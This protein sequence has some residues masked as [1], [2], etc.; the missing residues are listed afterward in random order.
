[1]KIMDHHQLFEPSFKI[2][3][4]G[5][6]KKQIRGK[7][8]KALSDS[9]DNIEKKA[10]ENSQHIV[11]RALLPQEYRRMEDGTDLAD[12]D[13]TRI[14]RFFTYYIALNKNESDAE[15]RYYAVKNNIIRIAKKVGFRFDDF[16]LLSTIRQQLLI[17]FSQ[18][19]QQELCDYRDDV[20]E[21]ITQFDQHPVL[22]HYKDA[23][24]KID[25][26]DQLSCLVV[27]ASTWACWDKQN[28]S[29]CNALANVLLP[30]G[31]SA[32]KSAVSENE[33]KESYITQER[34]KAK[35][36]LKKCKLAFEQNR[37]SDCGDLAMQ[38]I[39]FN[40]ADDSVL[41][42]A[43]F[44]LYIC[45]TRHDYYA[46]LDPKALLDQS[47]KLGCSDAFH[48][49][50]LQDIKADPDST[51]LLRPVSETSGLARIVT[52]T[53]N[54]Y[55]E[56]FLL[57]IPAEMQKED[58][59]KKMILSATHKKQLLASVDA[60]KDTRYLLFDE[61]QEKNFQDL[62]YLLEKIASE[63]RK[64]EDS[65][66]ISSLRWSKTT[67]Y[68]RVSED[69]YSSLIDTALK[70]LGNFTVRVFVLDDAKRAAQNLLSDYPLYESIKGL[71]N[72]TLT[73]GPVC[74]NFTIICNG[75]TALTSWLIREA[76]WTSCFSYPGLTV[77][78]HLISPFAKEIKDELRFHFP[79]MFSD[80][81][82]SDHVSSVTVLEDSFPV[83]SL[84]DHRI[85]QNFDG[86]ENRKNAFNYYVVNVG[87][88]IE[89]LNYGIKLREWSIRNRVD[90]GKSLQSRNLPVIAFYCQNS[91]VAYLS[92]NMV[93]QTIDHG[94]RWYNNY[95]LKPF[96]MLRDSYSW[97]S[98]DGVY[99]EMASQ[100]MHLQYCGISPDDL[101][102]EKA[103]SLKDYFSRSYNRDSSMSAAR[104]L[105]YRLFQVRHAAGDHI[106][107]YSS[108]DNTNAGGENKEIIDSM[109][110]QF[111]SAITN[112]SLKDEL[113]HS[114]LYY[115]HSRWIRWAY[116]RGWKKASP[117]QVI[118]YMDAGNPKQQLFIARLHGC[119]CSIDELKILSET[120]LNELVPDENGEISHKKDWNR[121]ASG[122]KAFR[123]KETDDER[124]YVDDYEYTP[125]D[126]TE[127]DIL[128]I[129]ATADLIQT[130][131]LDPKGIIE[132]S[133]PER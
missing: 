107:P 27:L 11:L 65:S 84:S 120:M 33:W 75:S 61:S 8:V 125:K 46:D 106:I 102:R 23:C 121:Y 1:M 25:F 3:L 73:R 24:L 116:S 81:P 93:I 66:F 68:I 126:F 114:L 38:I 76:Y 47:A 17:L 70:R 37:Y 85:F 39:E 19:S 56:E 112:P 20:H 9:S 41:G 42:E 103:V 32:D 91:Y 21:L 89:N 2:T 58:I 7:M 34:E 54:R 118:R 97:Y 78:I 40:F 115:E 77:N 119:L 132:L 51:M 129:A 64:S 44:H 90:A 96:G 92:Q 133:E 14:S 122:R 94:N 10:G 123:I 95:N 69:K 62:L 30:S 72:N 87:D 50:Q 36:L 60:S 22:S 16:E 83:S 108:I 80:L 53:S 4:A 113:I 110:E 15:N 100:S 31:H 45:C 71:S 74:I 105:P 63:E 88:D 59:L 111:R 29:D 12:V 55:T 18:F 101:T 26:Y 49:L 127:I 98:L 128:N 67:I 6:F 131:W 35:D 86:I 99:W 79:A 48:L 28:L 52:N 82:D 117:E 104:S 43:Y 109:A 124:G 13:S 57:S 130:R 5:L